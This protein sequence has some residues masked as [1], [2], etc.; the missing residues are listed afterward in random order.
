MRQVCGEARILVGDVLNCLET[1]WLTM[2]SSVEVTG[3]R[4]PEEVPP[5]T[6]SGVAP[7]LVMLQTALPINDV[8]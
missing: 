7:G 2:L 1:G 3:G 5:N 4:E 6:E 8:I